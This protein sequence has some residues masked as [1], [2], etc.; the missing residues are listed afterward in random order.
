MYH[1]VY[2]ATSPELPTGITIPAENA[3][4][5]LNIFFV[6]HPDAQFIIMYKVNSC[7]GDLEW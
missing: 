6:T 1:I 7:N 4:N 2:R 3:I 5:A